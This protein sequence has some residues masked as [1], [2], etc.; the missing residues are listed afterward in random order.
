MYLVFILGL[1]LNMLL[2][3]NL[4]GVFSPLILK[5][6]L[7]VG[8]PPQLMSRHLENVQELDCTAGAFAD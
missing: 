7:L 6:Y 3:V 1:L 8:D 2:E 5:I 4:V